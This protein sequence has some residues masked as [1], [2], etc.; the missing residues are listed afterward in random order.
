MDSWL[1]LI[2]AFGTIVLIPALRAG[3]RTY[4]AHKDLDEILVDALEAG[5]D[6]VEKKK[7]R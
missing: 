1:M 5:L 4:R 7:K 6:E 2:G 3:I